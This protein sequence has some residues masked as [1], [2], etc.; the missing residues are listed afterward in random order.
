MISRIALASILISLSA[1]SQTNRAWQTVGSPGFSEWATICS[2]IA[3]D[4]SGNVYVAYQDL[5]PGLGARV[6]VKRLVGDTWVTAGSSGAAST[7]AGYYCNMAFDGQNGL[8]VASRDY[9]L[10]GRAGVRRFD[11]VANTWTPLGGGIGTG[12]AHWVDVAVTAD[13]KPCVVYADYVLGNRSTAMRFDAGAWSSIGTTGF[14]AASAGFQKFAVAS[15]GGV[16]VAYNDGALPDPTGVGR[17]S[18]RKFNAAVGAW[19]YVGAAG[20]TPY[21]SPNLTLAID[22]TGVPWIAYYRY[23][24]SIEVWRFDGVNWVQAPGSPTGGD[25]PTVDSE[26]WRQWLSLQ[27]DAQNRP[28]VAYQLWQ[29]GR[30]AVV[31]RLEGGSWSV[32]G[33]W[34]F[35]PGAADYLSMIVDAQD[36]PWVVYRDGANGQRVSVMRYVPVSDS[37]CATMQNSLGCVSTISSS[38][39]PSLSA[40][41]P[42]QIRAGSVLSNTTGILVYGFQTAA[43]PFGGGTLCVGGLRRTAPSNSGGGGGPPSCSGVLEK[44]FGADLAAGLPGVWIGTTLYAQFWYRDANAPGGFSLS[45]GLRFVVGP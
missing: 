4:S 41:T 18:V 14:S 29:Y 25:L 36:T 40:T 31:R 7:G 3:S 24:H 10:L 28:Y 37:Y 2:R 16:Y 5:L 22:K 38:G 19:E 44:D 39:A 26:E 15:D 33:Q 12:E 8:L 45:N 21:G 42:F 1:H 32:L 11:P 30:K 35:T 17:A 9:G 23:H 13:G 20:F 34:G 6:T 43:A 27:F